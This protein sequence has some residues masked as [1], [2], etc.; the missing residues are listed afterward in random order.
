MF[1]NN[2]PAGGGGTLDFLG[3]KFSI[4]WEFL[5]KKIWEELLD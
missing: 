4:F 3:L 2:V 1:C 5:V